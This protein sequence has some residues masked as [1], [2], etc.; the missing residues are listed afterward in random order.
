MSAAQ[1]MERIDEGLPKLWTIH[2][3]LELRRRHP[4]WFGAE[5]AYRP[6][7]VAGSK[8]A[9][10]IAYLRGDHVVTIVPRL[11]VTLRARWGDT[12]VMLPAGEWRNLL[13]GATVQGG[14]VAVE[15]LLHDFPTALLVPAESAAGADGNGQ[16]A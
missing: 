16:D 3:A 13:S 14:K 6:L 15:A 8:R 4:E 2:H 9:H 11:I 12:A 5:S 7:E 1:V 10:V